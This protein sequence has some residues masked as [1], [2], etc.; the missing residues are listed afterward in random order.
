[1]INRQVWRYQIG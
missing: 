1:V